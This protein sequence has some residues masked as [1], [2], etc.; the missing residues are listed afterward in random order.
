M[1]LPVKKREAIRQNPRF[2][3]LFGKP[4]I[5]KTTVASLLDDNLII[6]MEDRGADYVSGYIVD[7]RSAKELIEVAKELEKSEKRYK[8]ITL[9]SATEMEDKIVMPLAIR[10]YQNTIIGKDYKGDDLRKLPMG[11]GQLGPVSD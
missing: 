11:A 10:L 2:M 6:E 3:V 8:Y 9:D 4:K 7:V 1:E 5:G